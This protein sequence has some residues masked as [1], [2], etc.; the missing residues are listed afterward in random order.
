[1]GEGMSRISW[2][3]A[4]GMAG[5]GAARLTA[6]DRWPPIEAPVAPLLS[7][8][9]QVAA[10]ALAS[11]LVLP[12]RGAAVTAGVTGVA[13][14]AVVVPRTI[15]R[16]QPPAAGPMLRVITAN[17]MAGRGSEEHVVGLVRRKAAD[18]LFLQELPES[19]VTR[20]KQ[21]GLTDLFPHAITDTRGESERG[22]GIYA[23][24]P[25]ASGLQ[26]QSVT[27]AQPT[28]RLELPGGR[29][30]DL[31]CV[32]S[33]PPNP[34]MSR[35][36]AARWRRELAVLP[37]PAACAAEPPRV[38]AGDFNASPDHAQ[39]RRLLRLGHVDA[40]SQLG[41]GL[42]PTW[43]PWGRPSLLT[44]DHVLVDPQCA[45]L[46]V[47]VHPLPGSDHRAVYAQFRLPG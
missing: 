25:L 11:A 45:V 5:W 6:A 34:P 46:D 39:F 18:V 1:M 9:P 47:T 37:P 19:A 41:K 32:H 15:R 16:P 2:L 13:L 44:L 20:L 12:R 43:G 30:A 38:L 10:T 8:T 42:I 26:L 27:A 31:V 23:R 22:S 29:H 28:A 33:Q 3:L 24:Y 35:Y 4:G 36:K 40:A 17:L 7:F 14:A 21:A